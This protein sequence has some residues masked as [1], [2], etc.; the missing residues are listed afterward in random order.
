MPNFYSSR[1]LPQD[2]IP[3]DSPED[4]PFCGSDKSRLFFKDQFRPYYRCQRCDLIFVP[5]LWQ[6]DKEQEKARYDTHENDPQEKGYRNYLRRIIS[7]MRAALERSLNGMNGLDYGCGPGPALAMMLEEEGAGMSLYDPFYFDDTS[8]LFRSY[9]FITCTEV[10][11]HMTQ[12]KKELEKLFSLLNPKGVLAVMTQLVTDKTDFNT[13]Y[14][15]NDE[16]HICYFSRQSFQWAAETWGIKVEFHG[17][18]IILLHGM[19]DK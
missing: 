1:E 4:C 18:D 10:I 12:P 17:K 5:R 2:Q 19:A 8:S 3:S 16:T 13:W 15:R 6:L 7:P 14:Y 9:D 11:E